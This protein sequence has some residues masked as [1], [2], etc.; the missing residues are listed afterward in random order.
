MRGYLMRFNLGSFLNAPARLAMFY[1]TVR[2][3]GA[4]T[5]CPAPSAEHDAYVR[6]LIAAFDSYAPPR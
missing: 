6:R 4:L 5:A 1:P 3:H 2:P